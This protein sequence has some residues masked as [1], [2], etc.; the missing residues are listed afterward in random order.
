MAKRLDRDTVVLEDAG[1]SPLWETLKPLVP[2]LCGWLFDTHYEDGTAKGKTRLQV[3]RVGNQIQLVL[4]DADSGLCV[5]VRHE[6]VQDGIM[7]LEL[8]LGSDECPWQLDPWPMR[9]GTKK[10][11]K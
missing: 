10:K 6:S 4:K 3:E 5:T 8:L 1:A 7:T 9:T 11:K 2:Q